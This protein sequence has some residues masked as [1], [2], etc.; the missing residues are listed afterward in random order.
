MQISKLIQSEFEDED[1]RRR[2]FILNVLLLGAV[3]L[4]ATATL[5]VLGNSLAKG[6][7]LRDSSLGVLLT[8]CMIFL[9][10]YFLSR[11]GFHVVSA[12]M[13]IAIYFASATYALYTF[14]ADLP[15]GLLTYSLIIIMAGIVISTRFA[16]LTTLVTSSTLLLLAYLQS[17][18]IIA[19]D[20]NWK[21]TTWR[22]E[23]TI[24]IIF[25][26]SVIAVAAWLSNREIERSL[27]LARKS[28]EALKKERDLLEARVAERTQE[29]KELQTEKILQLYQFSEFGRFAA[30]LLHDLAGSMI[31]ASEGTK[32]IERFV[33]AA[34]E[35]VREREM[36]T[37]FSAVDEINQAIQILGHKARRAG[38]EISLSSQ[39]EG[40]INSDNKPLETEP[41]QVFG[42]PM[43]FN[44]ITTNLISNAIDAY[45]GVKRNEDKKPQVLVELRQKNNTLSIIV[46]DRGAGISKEH[47]NKIFDPFFTTKS[48]EKGMGIG[49]SICKNIVENDFHGRMEVES[50]QGEGTTFRVELPIK[51]A[52]KKSDENHD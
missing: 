15:E 50:K 18:Q 25:I 37:T 36:H 29:L 26:L 9:F 19:T 13:L 4:S 34:R 20:P 46:Q 35:Q 21:L 43:K 31:A 45:D 16:L 51:T 33:Q 23:N 17:N 22:M 28:E 3:V 39:F 40:E 5:L 32:H 42:N 30:G 24:T 14:G 12:Y 7:G 47:I 27:E 11:I 1:V 52:K 8:I 38:V 48:S 2:E 49:L 10:L 44:Q 6:L 41:F